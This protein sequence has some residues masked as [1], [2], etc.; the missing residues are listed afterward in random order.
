MFGG[1]MQQFLCACGTSGDVLA[2]LAEHTG[3]S[4]TMVRILAARGLEDEESI[5]GF[6]HPDIRTTPDPMLFEDMDRAIW[7]IGKALEEKRHFTIYGDY[8]VDGVTSTSLLY[9]YFKSLGA[10]VDYYIP[11]RRKEDM[12]SIWTRWMPSM[13]G[14]RSSSS[15]WTT[16][17]PPGW[18]WSTQRSWA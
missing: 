4:D 10:K 16:A 12:G 6:L 1:S 2:G 13:P 3:L 14:G 18:R 9:L 11:D 15:P 7:E 8:D 17:S 5:Q